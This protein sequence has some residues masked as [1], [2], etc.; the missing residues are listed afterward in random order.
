MNAMLGT[1]RS[2][3]RKYNMLLPRFRQ[4]QVR[5]R[6]TGAERTIVFIGQARQPITDEQQLLV[7]AAAQK[8]AWKKKGIEARGSVSWQEQSTRSQNSDDRDLLQEQ[9]T[10]VS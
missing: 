5:N 10:S 4:R 2:A 3:P 9:P 6:A 7:K 8:R 1:R